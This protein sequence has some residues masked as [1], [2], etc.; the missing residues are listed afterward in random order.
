MVVDI[1][2][3]F[4][5]KHAL[6]GVII[7]I[8]AI[9]FAFYLPGILSNLEPKQCTINGVCQHEQYAKFLAEISPL[10]I[11]IG[12]VIGAIV[13]FVMSSRL[14]R[15]EKDFGTVIATFLKWKG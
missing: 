9:A 5:N 2:F 13:F 11:L 8:C 1:N 15:K 3:N 14:E 6:V 12:V 7:L 10:F 4:S